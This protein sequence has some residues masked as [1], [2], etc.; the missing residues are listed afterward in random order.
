M[1]YRYSHAYMLWEFLDS[2]IFIFHLI[3]TGH[4]A[5][6]LALYCSPYQEHPPK[7]I[8]LMKKNSNL[9]LMQISL[10]FYSD[11]FSYSRYGK[12]SY[13]NYEQQRKTLGNMNF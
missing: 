8:A 1:Y 9:T 10:I 11:D 13:G 6:T 3:T 4:I 12:L 2:S 5:P 7:I